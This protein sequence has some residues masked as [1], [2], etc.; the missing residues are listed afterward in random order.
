MRL[1]VVSIQTFGDYLLKAPFI[2]EL[3]SHYPNSDIT[4]VTNAKGA[5]V[6]PL[7]D[8]RLR[9]VVVDKRDSITSLFSKMITL[10]KADVL[11][12]IDQNPAS[13]LLSF[14]IRA[15]RRVGWQQSVSSLYHGPNAGFRDRNSV[16]SILAFLLGFVLDRRR[17]REPEDSY[18]GHVEL[19][20][21]DAPSIRQRL[22]Q[23]RTAY[24]MHPE[25]KS[26]PPFIFVGTST[27]WK[28]RQ[29]SDYQWYP[30]LLR[31]L[32][33]FPVHRII[34]DAPDA[35]IARFQGSPRIQKLHKSDQLDSVFRLV[36]SADAIICS[37]SFLTHLASWFD[38]PAVAFFGPAS[39]HRFS[40]TAPGS[41]VLFHR[42]L[43]SP[44]V[45]QRDSSLCLAG[46]TQCL[47]LQQITCEEVCAA[48]SKA[49]ACRGR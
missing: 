9:I 33:M 30:I 29:L 7:V 18:E 3:Y 5:M 28:A 12:L 14:L 40:P 8:S 37:D 31:I 6:Y 2:Y 45:Q 16:N 43:C 44:C 13:S 49:I 27:S 10:P 17:L 48:I 46:Y 32:E 39:P 47:S 19:G 23:Y 22:A 24:S 11:Y 42:P 38:V 20:L 21:L 26:S 1:T 35:L 34:I 41:T 4:I 36:S 25:P 15:R